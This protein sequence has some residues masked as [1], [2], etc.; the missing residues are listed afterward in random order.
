MINARRDDEA[1]RIAALRR[2]NVLDTVRE[3]PFDKITE[4]VCT[5]L[6]VPIS[7]VSLIDSDRQW[8]KSA[9]GVDAIQTP[10]SG[11][12]CAHTIMRD[13]ALVVPDALCDPRFQSSPFVTGQPHL[14]SY[15]GVPLQTSD[16]YNLG[17]L[18]AIDTVAREFD[19]AQIAILTRFA[20]LVVDEL[21]LRLI[22]ERDYLTGAL[23]RRG[24]VEQVRKEIARFG[25]H[26]RGSVLALFDVDHF[27]SV[28]DRFGHPAG[29]RV[30][31]SIASVCQTMVRA[32]DAFGRLGGEE[33]ALLIAD[34]DMAGAMI[35][36]EKFRR[37]I[38][39]IVVGEPGQIRVTASFGL[40]ALTGGVASADA[41]IAQADEA[42]YASKRDGRNRCSWHRSVP[43]SVAA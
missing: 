20:A 18:C 41:W 22:A 34:T 35:A 29:D 32:D 36:A 42:L 28:N 17:A 40:A 33:F 1:G 26:G 6:D 27:K 21:E 37:A 11:T 5:V 39:G 25:R 31:T 24:F 30:L 13:D 3:Q 15:L 12:F 2:Y 7:T 14:R 38:A 8:F 43:A 10:R 9:S 19:A 23:T 4:L 16:G